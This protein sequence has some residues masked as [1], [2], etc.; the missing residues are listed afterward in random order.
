MSTTQGRKPKPESYEYSWFLPAGG[1]NGS[2]VVHQL[3][4][5]VLEA[6]DAQ[7]NGVDSE[8]T[9]MEARTEQWRHSGVTRSRSAQH[10]PWKLDQ[11][12][13]RL[14]GIVGWS[15]MAAIGGILLAARAGPFPGV[16]VGILGAAWVGISAAIWFVPQILSR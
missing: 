1:H 4:P 5:S 3:P 6:A 16:Q 12:K 13:L 14:A 9:A 10:Q 2:A 7:A 11:A 15:G 8:I